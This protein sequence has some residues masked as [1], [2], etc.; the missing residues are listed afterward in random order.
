MGFTFGVRNKIEESKGK[1]NNIEIQEKGAEVHLAP[2]IAN[3][4]REMRS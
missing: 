3:L 1:L 4:F 2:K